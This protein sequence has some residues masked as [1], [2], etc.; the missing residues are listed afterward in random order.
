MA[1][2]FATARETAGAGETDAFPASELPAG[3]RYDAVLA[4]SRSG[5][6]TEVVR[7]LA[8]LPKSLPTYAIVGADGTP[9]AAAA[10]HTVALDFAD[11]VSVVQTRFA[12]TTLV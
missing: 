10:E 2:A 5:T 11:E 7:G 4:I 1:Q 12:T 9:V 3:R 8:Q 6:T